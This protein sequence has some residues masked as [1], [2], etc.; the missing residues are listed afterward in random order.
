[1]SKCFTL[2]RGQCKYLSNTLTQQP[3][4][5][6]LGCL[7]VNTKIIICK[8]TLSLRLLSPQSLLSGVSIKYGKFTKSGAQNQHLMHKVQD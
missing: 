3:Y 7:S 1:M 2:T 4:V 6:V 8:V 5:N